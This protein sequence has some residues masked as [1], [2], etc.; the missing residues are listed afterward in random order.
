MTETLFMFDDMCEMP[1]QLI[2]TCS[3]NT[4]KE[5]ELIVTMSL[6]LTGRHGQPQNNREGPETGRGLRVPATPLCQ[7]NPVQT[8]KSLTESH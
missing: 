4:I 5:Y 2:F 6:L 3:K 7:R 8:S 1:E